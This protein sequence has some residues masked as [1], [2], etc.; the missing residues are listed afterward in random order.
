MTDHRAIHPSGGERLSCVVGVWNEMTPYRLHVL[1]RIR[2]ELRD[3]R[4][5]N[6]FTHSV[7]QNSMPWKIQADGDLNIVFDPKRRMTRSRV[8]IGARLRTASLIHETV[9]REKP[10]FVI[11]HGHNDL[12]RLLTMRKLNRLRVP[13]AHASDGNAFDEKA[14]DGPLALLRAL[15]LRKLLQRMG[16]YLVM[17]TGGRGFYQLHGAP[18]VPHFQFP[19]EPDLMGI[20]ACKTPDIESF[21][22]RVALQPHRKTFLYSGRLVPVKRVDLVLQAFLESSESLREWDLVVAGTGPLR[23]ALE[24]SVPDWL[25][26]RVRFTGFLQPEEINA[27]YRSCDV[28]VHASMREPWGLVIHEAVAAG[29]AVIA[30]DIAGSALELVRHRING[31]LVRPGSALALSDAMKLVAEPGTLERMRANSARVL[32]DWRESGDPIAGLREAIRHFRT[33]ALTP[34]ELPRHAAR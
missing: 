7:E 9:D 30:T 27:A 18:H 1:R 21:R 25:R 24:R 29:M 13:M 10:L 17:G 26:E 3:V 12:A 6:I 20:R 11:M 23:E 31:L 22:A 8:S 34:S 19:Y 14:A 32:E 2:D 15:Y 33:R 4:M 5:V 16:A 28:L